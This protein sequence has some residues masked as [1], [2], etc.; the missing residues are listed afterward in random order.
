MNTGQP[1]ADALNLYYYRV[2]EN[3][4][5]QFC[6]RGL[7]AILGDPELNSRTD[8]LVVKIRLSH[9]Q[10]P[11]SHV[12]YLKNRY[13]WREDGT[14]ESLDHIA[15]SI[16]GLR[17]PWF[18]ARK[19]YLSYTVSTRYVW[20]SAEYL[21]FSNRVYTRD[22]YMA[23]ENGI[24]TW[25][26]AEGVYAVFPLMRNV[27]RFKLTASRKPLEGGSHMLSILIPGVKYGHI[28]ILSV[29]GP[30]K[31]VISPPVQHSGQRRWPTI[32]TCELPPSIHRVID[33]VKNVQRILDI[34][35]RVEPIK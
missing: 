11:G 19:M 31:R 12:V 6:G 5:G 9:K 33:P 7:A 17:V 35:V 15:R 13:I 3:T 30:D 29:V 16:P 20:G 34:Y 8:G 24:S 2:G 4:I 23:L 18:F 1:R 21:L 14:P 10:H 22:V 25:L 27:K 26:C 28:T 32:P